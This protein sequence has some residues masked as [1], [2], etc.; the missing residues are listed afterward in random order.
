VARQFHPEPGAGPNEEG[1]I[2]KLLTKEIRQQ[3][4]RLYATENEED[5]IVHVKF[6]SPWLNWTWY[7]TY[8]ELGISGIMRSL[9]LCGAVVITVWD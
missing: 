3:L 1:R 5:P 8:A 9:G 7:A 4:P 2:M 6:F